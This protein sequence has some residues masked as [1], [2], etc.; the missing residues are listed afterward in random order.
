MFSLIYYTT[1]TS[2]GNKAGPT[3]LWRTLKGKNIRTNDGTYEG[4]K[5]RDAR[6]FHKATYF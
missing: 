6:L 5:N 4:Y 3:T 1:M 2:E